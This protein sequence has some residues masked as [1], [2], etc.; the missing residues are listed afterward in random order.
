MFLSITETFR[1][2][3]SERRHLRRK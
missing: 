1:T 3:D 2:T